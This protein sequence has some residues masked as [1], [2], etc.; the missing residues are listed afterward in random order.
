M[1]T[2]TNAKR[3]AGIIAW[4][5]LFHVLLAYGLPEW[6]F[7]VLVLSLSVLYWRI[8]ALGALTISITLILVTVLYSLTLKLTGLEDSIYYRP[9]EKYVRFDYTHNHRLYQ[10]KVHLDMSMP[11]GDLRAMTTEDIAEPRRI[12][13]H[14]DADGFRNERDYHGQRYL[15][16]GDSFIAGNSNSQED[17]LV[18]QLLRDHGLDTYSLAYP[19]NPADYAAYMRG[20]SSRY[21]ENFRVLL[22]LFE[23]N[24]FEE[25][26]G[27]KASV[28]ARYGRR[29]YE[30]FSE[31]NTYRVTGSLLK[32]VTRARSI[33][34]G[35]DLEIATLGGKKLAFYRLYRDVTRRANLPNPVGFERAIESMRPYIE[36]VYFIP[37]KYR[38][39]ARHL[40]PSAILPHA[41]WQYLDNICRKHQLRCTDLTEPLT[42][43]SDA[44]LSK[45]EFTWWR[46]DTHWNRNGIAVAARVVAADLVP[47]KPRSNR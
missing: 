35:S 29:Y 14:T 22:F 9:D 6:L 23:G 46:D 18:T 1:S 33:H 27:R 39:Y 15:L 28:L 2:S 19:G 12:Q 11:H 32:R 43:E 7:I 37:T 45:G 26:R 41:Q 31:L 47:A 44:L 10:N 24:D 20:F 21:G 25:S 3:V 34:A 40:T 16:V 8:G 42:R 36:R 4:L 30:M 17:L 13:F 38:V 5:F